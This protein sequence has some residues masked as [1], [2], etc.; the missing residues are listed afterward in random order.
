VINNESTDNT[1]FLWFHS[2]ECDVGIVITEKDIPKIISC[3]K[4]ITYKMNTKEKYFG[5]IKGMV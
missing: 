2:I 4:E 3:L 1:A 5:E